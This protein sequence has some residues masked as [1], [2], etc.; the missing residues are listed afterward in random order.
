MV[1]ETVVA[2]KLPIKI[3][4]CIISLDNYAEYEISGYTAGCRTRILAL[5]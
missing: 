1:A 5:E 3:K 2:Y 4:P